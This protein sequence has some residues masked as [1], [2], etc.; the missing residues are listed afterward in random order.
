MHKAFH[1]VI[2]NTRPEDYLQVVGL[3][4]GGVAAEGRGLF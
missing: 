2:Q 1:L 4:V 3:A